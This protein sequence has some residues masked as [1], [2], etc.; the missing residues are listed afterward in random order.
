MFFMDVP[1]Y[2]RNGVKKT[3]LTGGIFALIVVP[4]LI[5]DK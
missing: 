5:S 3:A 2:G 1:Q 4:G